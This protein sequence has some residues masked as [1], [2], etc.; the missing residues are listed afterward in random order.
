MINHRDTEWVARW[1]DRRWQSGD[2]KIYFSFGSDA[3]WIMCTS[4]GACAWSDGFTEADQIRF[5]FSSPVMATVGVACSYVLVDKDGKASWN[6][7]GYYSQLD[8]F[9]GN[10]A[11]AVTVRLFRVT[12]RKH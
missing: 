10:N 7:Q 8:H 4:K 3:N 9:L 2:R 1:I 11:L 5:Q 12:Y 6:L